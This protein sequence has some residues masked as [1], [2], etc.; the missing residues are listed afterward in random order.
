MRQLSMQI[1]AERRPGTGTFESIDPYTGEPWA[2]VPEATRADV[3]DAVA[4]ARAA[5]EGEWGALTGT[6]RGRLLRR[7]GEVITESADDL[8][9][10][11]TRDNGKLLRE[12]GGQVRGLP[13]WYEY[14]A[15]LA[16]KIDGR[17]VDTGRGDF[18]GYVSREPVG[19]VGSILPWN[20]PLLLL[21]FKLA[22]ALAAGCTMIAKP[23]EQAPVSILL[24]AE[25]F[26]RAGFPP[27]V[28][29]T[30]SGASRQVGEWLS[31]HPGVDH[32]SFTGSEA[33]GAAVAKAAAGHLA[34]ATL[35]LGGKSANIVFPDADLAA[36][37]NGLVAGIFAAAGQTCIAGSRGLVHEDVYDE[38]L[39]GV[40]DR[41]TRIV[42]G[43]PQQPETEMGPI[44][45]PGQLQKIQ[46]FV[47]EAR[48][49]GARIVT[50]GDD[51][52]M[53]G[54][55]FAPTIIADV[56]NDSAV[57]QEE[58]F[59]PVLSMLRF[60]DEEEAVALA[61][62]SRYGLAAGLWTR[63]IQRVFRMTKRLRVGTVWVNAYRT[64]NFAM[65][66]GGVKASGF[67]REN[68]SEGLHE[69]LRDKAV[70]IETT[71]GTRDPFVLG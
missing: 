18:F 58:I 40:A 1:G 23:S 25:L 9:I 66:F 59:G 53:G 45:F 38:I 61:N 14:Y 43:D 65:P 29:N 19:V 3:D 11:E 16:D 22:P 56:T 10:A 46:K 63:D 67:G 7:L 54:L 50:G 5:F 32:V 31:S 51:R 27:G 47:H 57:C 39:E 4:A 8:A 52:D 26:E 55:F 12:M 44:C 69:Y 62:D 49:S 34:P 33:T 48:D 17:V 64:L 30:V 21:T 2:V 71:G 68:G 42:M 41:A 70:W 60:K 37:A 28:F 24:L 20:S 35:E 6:A 15:G 36:A 13:A